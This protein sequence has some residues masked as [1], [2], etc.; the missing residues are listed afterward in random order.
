MYRI[1]AEANRTRCVW[2]LLGLGSQQFH[3]EKDLLL[4][5]SV[6]VLFRYAD[7]T[8]RGRASL[9]LIRTMRCHRP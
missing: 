6:A 5:F 3:H 8:Q 1:L 9:P 2:L 4:L 7:R